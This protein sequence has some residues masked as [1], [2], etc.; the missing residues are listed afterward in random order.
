MELGRIFVF[1]LFLQ[2]GEHR[3]ARGV[4]RRL[5]EVQTVHAPGGRGPQ[6]RAPDVQGGP[7]LAGVCVQE[8]DLR[9]RRQVERRAG[10]AVP[11]AAPREH[12][13]Q[14]PLAHLLLH[15]G[16]AGLVCPF[17][18]VPRHGLEP[19][20]RPHEA[21]PEGRGLRQRGAVGDA[22]ADDQVLRVPAERVRHLR[23]K[24][25]LLPEVGELLLDVGHRRHAVLGTRRA[26]AVP[27]GLAEGVG[28][29]GGPRLQEL[30][31]LVL[32]PQGREG[33][34]ERGK[35]GALVPQPDEG[36]DLLA[37]GPVQQRVRPGPGLLAGQRGQPHLRGG[38]RL[39]V[40]PLV[41]LGEE[42]AQYQRREDLTTRQQE[43]PWLLQL[44]RLPQAVV[45]SVPEAAAEGA[46]GRAGG[47]KGRAGT[48]E[49]PKPG[50]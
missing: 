2:C 17:V 38:A 31:E 37:A 13:G 47:R 12:E 11:V 21:Q 14:Q 10:Y 16:D 45:L 5:G 19:G 20:P 27:R 29:H 26:L 41:L 44:P 15:E 32:L 6:V 9:H 4:E 25:V 3:Q 23:V 43:P 35:L 28:H 46:H 33:H 8:D 50:P 42:G 34:V 48:T 36:A 22:T 30:Q 7:A 1:G 39:H 40:V 24:V 18:G 49:R